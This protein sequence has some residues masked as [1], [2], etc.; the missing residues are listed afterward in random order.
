[1]VLVRDSA[2]ERAVEVCLERQQPLAALLAELSAATGR[3][4]GCFAM[5]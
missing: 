5:A 4:L 2:A 1:M 3:E